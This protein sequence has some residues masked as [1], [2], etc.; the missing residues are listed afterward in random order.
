MKPLE[1]AARVLC[2]L[3]ENLSGATMGGK[4]LWQDYLVEV[5]VVLEAS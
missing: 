5:Q 2:E 3:D 4:P 1:R